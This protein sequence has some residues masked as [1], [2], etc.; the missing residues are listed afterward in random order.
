MHYARGSDRCSY[1]NVSDSPGRRSIDQDEV[2]KTCDQLS[3]HP[4]LIAAM[5]SRMASSRAVRSSSVM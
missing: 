3:T 4:P 5:P 1:E 2:K